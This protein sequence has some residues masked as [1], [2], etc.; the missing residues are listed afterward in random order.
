M[1]RIIYLVEIFKL[2]IV[3]FKIVRKKP[4]NLREMEYF[5]SSGAHQVTQLT[6]QLRSEM[7]VIIHLSYLP[8]IKSWALLFTP[9]DNHTIAKMKEQADQQSH[10]PPILC[11]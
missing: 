7:T 9:R 8:M 2:N 10:L 1:S 11:Q 3:F 4:Q 5:Y 6:A